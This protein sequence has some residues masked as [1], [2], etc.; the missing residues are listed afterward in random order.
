MADENQPKSGKTVG[1]APKKPDEIKSYQDALAVKQSKGAKADT[2]RLKHNRNAKPGYEL[3][4]RTKEAATEDRVKRAIA[5][6]GVKTYGA[7]A[8]YVQHTY[9][10]I[11][12]YRSQGLTYSEIATKP[13]MPSQGRISQLLADDPAFASICEKAY[14]GYV[15]GLVERQLRLIETTDQSVGLGETPVEMVQKALKMKDKFLRRDHLIAARV[16]TQHGSAVASA[17]IA[18][19]GK[20]LQTGAQHDPARW[21]YNHDSAPDVIVI[22]TPDG[23]WM[24]AASARAEEPDGQGQQAAEARDEWARMRD[25]TPE[26]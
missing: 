9:D 24:D 20:A 22:E 3:D 2:A 14:D 17:R 25:V 21:G 1:G 13:Y 4:D 19:V 5:K 16:L 26:D 8:K 6:R 11:A 23:I 10:Q 7:K 18:R 15:N 12:A